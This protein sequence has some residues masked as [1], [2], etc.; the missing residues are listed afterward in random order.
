M[1]T[2]DL[3]DSFSYIHSLAYSFIGVQT[4]YLATY[5]PAVYWNT[6]C[7][8]VDSGLEESASTD[9]NKI[10]KAVGNIIYRGIAI[11]LIDINKSQYMFEP[12]EENNQIIYGMKALNGV[13]GEVIQEIVDNRPYTSVD[14]F[15]SKV[16]INRTGMLS[17]I[18]S[19][20]FDQF[21]NRF[22]IMKQYILD[23]SEPKKRLTLQ[24]FNGLLEKD[25]IPQ[26]LD[27]SRRVFVFNKVFRKHKKG[28]Y[29]I[30]DQSNL[31]AFYEKFFDVD[32]LEPVDS[33]LGILQKTWKKIYDKEMLPAKKYI[34]EN[35]ET[36]LEKYNGSLFQDMWNKYVSGNLATWEMD[37]LG[38]Y[39]H[40]HELAKVNKTLYNI[41]EYSS[42][43]KEPVVDY[44]FKRNDRQIPIYKTN[45]IMGTVV[46][47]DD[48]H[49]IISILT[50][51]SGVV[52]VKMSRDY[53]ARYNRQISEEFPDGTKKVVEK[54][55]FTRGTLVV[56]NGIRRGDLFITKSYK[57][58]PSHQLYKITNVNIGNGTIDMTNCRYGEEED[59]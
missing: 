35:Q 33:H 48:T 26:E 4:I 45:R 15:M 8:R 24:N 49:S 6:A 16:S 54:G 41:V 46:A 29:L 57:N 7:L 36:L 44:Y 17:L 30:F 28:D 58:T 14:D 52:N 27:F 59:I 42:L 47:K 20:A 51:N 12:D 10:A 2:L 40:E 11:S 19:G 3:Y 18:K 13:G 55:W 22:N 50:V 1:E 53:F 31:Y 5:F 39:Y 23:I 21:D 34:Q 25:L 38:M 56:V 9:Y 37:S 43:S 32:L